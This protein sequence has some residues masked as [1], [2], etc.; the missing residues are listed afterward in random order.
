[1]L[2]CL[3]HAGGSNDFSGPGCAPSSL[4]QLQELGQIPLG[5][6][7]LEQIVES[8]FVLRQ[9][10]SLGAEDV[11]S[12]LLL[13][14][15]VP[16]EADAYSGILPLSDAEKVGRLLSCSRV[17]RQLLTSEPSFTSRTKSRRFC[18]V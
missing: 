1:M 3:L 14:H 6:R 11:L 17:R 9:T 13:M 2:D 4:S 12:Q 7:S 16:S 18:R 15:Q 10:A 8:F 5:E